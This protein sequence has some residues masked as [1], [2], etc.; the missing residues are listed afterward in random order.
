VPEPLLTVSNLAYAYGD[1]THALDDVTFSVAPGERV[2]IIGPNG[3]G[4]S[5]LLL[6]LGGLF[7][8]RGNV[9]I[10][11]LQLTSA[12]ARRLRS[13]LGL[14]FQSPDDQLFMP[15]LE[16]DLAFGPVNLG[17][18]QPQVHERVHRVADQFA[19]SGMLDKA[20]HHLS[21]GQKRSAAI[22]AVLAMEPSILLMDE[23]S[24]N[25][26]P[27]GRRQ[28]M[29]ALADLPAAMLIASHD[30]ALVAA[31]CTR[32][33]L[34]DG[35]RIVTEGPTTAILGDATLMEAHGLEAWPLR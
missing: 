12:T 14:V 30:L 17:L 31:L 10:E 22:A 1:G 18:S 23:P 20:P 34:L 24:S 2:G 13:H 6:C 4:K 7:F 8:G 25:L 15:T 33:V 32:I 9:T 19:L 28:L 5:T 16:D 29:R 26:D 21:M 11:G 27:R 35:G 3:S